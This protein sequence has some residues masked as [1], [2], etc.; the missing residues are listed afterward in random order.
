MDATRLRLGHKLH[1]RVINGKLR[2]INIHNVLQNR[3]I[4]ILH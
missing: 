2:A 4:V 3:V 1:W